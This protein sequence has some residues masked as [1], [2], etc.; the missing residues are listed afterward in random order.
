MGEKLAEEYESALR[1]YLRQEGEEP[2]FTVSEIAK[3]L[4]KDHAGPDVLMDIHANALSAVIRDEG[5]AEAA[6]VMASANTLLL[7]AMMVFAMTYHSLFSQVKSD[8]KKL[9]QAYAE[10][11]KA[12]ARLRDL[13][14]LKLIFIASMSH[15]L[16]TPLNS[17]IG[18]SSILLD[19][20]T[21]GL[22]PEQ[23]ANLG[24]VLRAG[25]H[26]LSIVNDVIDVSKVESG[27][28]EPMIEEFD[29]NDLIDEAVLFVS[30]DILG[31]G[32]EIKVEAMRKALHTDRRRLLQSVLN[33]LS[34]AVKFTEKGVISISAYGSSEGDSVSISITD[35][36]VGIRAE[37]I[38]RLFEP[39]CRLDSSVKAPGTGLGLYLTRKIVTEILGGEVDCQS[40]FGQG[41]RF[42]I[43]IPVDIRA[44]SF[45]MK[46]RSL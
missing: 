11:E 46:G 28:I 39:F 10:L 33:L 41:S 4:I 12:H 26:L 19:E 40:G 44:R 36:G 25:R 45:T 1:R 24:I 22:S 7:H 2:L 34:N 27:M 15:E 21:G 35:T 18:F 42:T 32:L 6:T 9:E 16:R 14:R 31:K 43:T 29:L 20:W 17:I 37:D 23:K 8:K 3:K 30:K 13:D 38:P 5:T